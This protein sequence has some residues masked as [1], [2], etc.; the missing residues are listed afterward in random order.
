[1]P[2][3]VAQP[4]VER[5]V[6]AGE[7]DQH[8]DRDHR[9]RDR[10]T[11]PGDPGGRPHQRGG[12]QPESVGDDDRQRGGQHR[13]DRGEREAVPGELEEEAAEQRVA[14]VQRHLRQH[15]DRH[16]EAQRDRCQ[17]GSAGERAAAAA[18]VEGRP[19]ARL[20]GV[21][22]AREPARPA[23]RGKHQQHQQHQRSG[24]LR[25]RDRLAEREPGPVDAGREGVDAEVLDGAE[26][27]QRLHQRERHTA[28]DRGPGE[29]HG[30]FEEAAP[31]PAA[32][33]AADVE[34]A[35]AL[36]EERRARQQIDVGVEHQAHTVMAPPSERICG[37]Q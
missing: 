29:R 10:I 15:Q 36:L 12:P 26:I 24:Q 20:G 35:G 37:N 25:R 13:G 19:Q 1:M 11:D 5:V 17:A 6:G 18:Q 33:R 30:D 7:R 3:L 28:G 34:H 32:E 22:V 31:R 16:A 23:L 21:L 27:G 14:L 4:A 8:A 9:A 2:T